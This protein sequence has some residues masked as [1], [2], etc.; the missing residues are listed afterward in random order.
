MT[1]ARAADAELTW[2]AS[3]LTAALVT[4]AAVAFV[5]AVIGGCWQLVAFAAPLIGVLCSIGWQ[6]PVPSARVHAQPGAHR[7][8]ETEQVRVTV[9]ADAEPETV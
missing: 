5:V 4:C 2:R 9:W 1:E 3:P 6:R 7:C 8:F